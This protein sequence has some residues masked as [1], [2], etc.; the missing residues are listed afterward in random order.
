M[1]FVRSVSLALTLACVVLASSLHAQP[2]SGARSAA[3]VENR[4]QWDGRARFRASFPGLDAWVTDS[5]IVYDY[6]RADSLAP[7]DAS[8]AEQLERARIARRV[9][10]V[11]AMRFVGAD[12]AASASREHRLDGREN[13]FLGNDPSRWARGAER[14]DEVR[15]EHLYDG[16]DARLAVESGTLRYDLIVA[17][18]A[19]PSR[20]AIALEGAD[21]MRVDAAGDLVLATSVG[22][23]RHRGLLAYQL[24]DGARHTVA[25]RFVPR[26]DG[27]LGFELGRYDRSRPL[28]IDPI[29]WSM[30]YGHPGESSPA[31]LAVDSVGNVYFTGTIY[32]SGYPTRFGSYD[33]SFNGGVDAVVTRINGSN[34]SLGYS[35][36]IGGSLDEFSGRI[37]INTSG[38][39]FIAMLTTSTD[40]PTTSGAFDEQ[41]NGTGLDAAI[42]R[43]NRGGDA[44]VYST[45]LGGADIEDGVDVTVDASDQ[46]YVSGWT[47]SSNFPTTAGALATSYL[48]GVSDGFVSVLTPSGASLVFSTLF[49]GAG[50]DNVTRIAL[51]TIGAVYIAGFT[52]S[53]DFPTTPGVLQRVRSGPQDAFIAKINPA[54]TVLMYSTLLGGSAHEGAAFLEVGKD[55]DVYVAGLTGSTDFPVTSGS[56]Q[57]RPAGQYVAHIDPYASATYYSTF[58]GGA[59]N[60]PNAVALAR[61]GFFCITGLIGAG[62]SSGYPTSSDAV[63]RSYGGGAGDAYVTIVRPSGGTLSYSTYLGGSGYDQGYGIGLD[64][65]GDVY[66]SGGTTS[67]NFP[68]TSGSNSGLTDFF[69]TKI[70]RCFVTADAG[71]DRT[72]CFGDSAVI[73]A[74]AA[75][76]IPPYSYRWTATGPLAPGDTLATLTVRPTA[77]ATYIVTA[78]DF[79]GCD[80]VD[81]VVVLVNTPPVV[82]AGRDTSVC[83]GSSVR[84]GSAAVGSGPFRYAWEPAAG[85]DVKTS[86]RPMARPDSTTSYVVTVSDA[87][88]CIGRDTVV[89]TVTEPPTLEPGANFEICAGDT[90]TLG[91]TI[92]RGV[93]PFRYRWTPATGLSSTTASAPL[94]FPSSTTTY[95]VTVTDSNGCSS[96]SAPMTVAVGSTLRARITANRSLRLCSGDSVTLDAGEFAEYLWSNGSRGRTITV[97]DPGAYFVAIRSASGCEGTSDTV[98]VTRAVPPVTRFTG[99]IVVCA[100]STSP[101]RAE[102]GSGTSLAWRIRGSAGEIVSA[103]GGELVVD[104]Q[105]SGIDTVFLVA[106]SSDGCVDSA[107]MEVRVNAAPHPAI[108]TTG[109]A[110]L[111][112]GD[113]LVLDGGAGYASY[114]WSDGSTTRTIVVRAAGEYWVDVVDAIGCAGRSDTVRVGEHARPALVVSGTAL[115]GCAGDTAVLVATAGFASYTWSNGQTGPRIT[116]SAPGRYS[117]T[118]VDTS[119]CSWTS[120][121]SEVIRHP[122]PPPPTITVA[123]DTLIASAAAAYRWYRDG[124]AIDTATSSRLVRGAS[125]TYA[126]EITDT[127]GCR[128]RT[129]VAAL[130]GHIVWMDTVRA[131]VG[132]R[133]VIGMLVSPPLRSNDGVSRYDI[134]LRHAPSALFANSARAASSGATPVMSAA[135][136][137]TISVTARNASVV[138]D[139]VFSLEM[140]GLSTGSPQNVVEIVSAELGAAPVTVAG[141]GLV[142]L[143]G[144][145]IGTFAAGKAVRIVA[146]H[147]DAESGSIVVEYRAPAGSRPLLT[148]YDATGRAIITRSLGEDG[149]LDRD[150]T[151]PMPASGLYVIEL[152]DRDERSSAPSIVTR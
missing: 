49:G 119:G 53:S 73:G 51:D 101:Y 46:A 20:V 58:L 32:S 60:R 40:F 33:V 108:A 110:M 98:A 121:E 82:A 90:T 31:S 145:D 43:L 134:Q 143:D 35:T 67:T 127:N 9:G 28:V 34:L 140:T 47:T 27:R 133:F 86:A 149:A 36:Y 141:N 129:S 5:G 111:C 41:K 120:T 112:A 63:A 6:Y 56:F 25:C 91:V 16:V 30:Y 44:L 12:G 109:D 93:P 83:R 89:V 104:W 100:G 69:I 102:A 77:S 152:R 139:T 59:A 10:T 1:P 54:G 148:L 144:C 66:V 61:G 22:E 116:V 26:A 29:V 126:V 42:V 2:V 78:T 122:L 146:T 88:G 18:N 135:P 142:L 23:V 38:E 130:E 4:G 81:T 71:A 103:N 85:L 48:G 124:I 39:A 107:A 114:R 137:G 95:T 65:V 19:D 7:P 128:S 50:A 72:I 97:A 75:R 17:P 99:Q 87:N 8:A 13:F 11:V 92:S 79:V 125:G 3:F 138:G 15:L 52:E 117:V 151:I 14:F 147:T 113:S 94:A 68:V 76:G 115:E 45:F 132:D 150:A 70:A 64:R 80:D 62:G 105:R 96:T 118:V 37:A 74:P 21:A 84:I 57:S 136:D 123:G 131:R 24:I 106:V 55:G